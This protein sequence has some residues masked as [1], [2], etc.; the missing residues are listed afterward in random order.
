MS[1]SF[2]DSLLE[3]LE[4]F[5][6]SSN[7]VSSQQQKIVAFLHQLLIEIKGLRANI[8]ELTNESIWLRS[9]VEGIQKD[10]KEMV[11]NDQIKN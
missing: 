11:E 4:S 10:V 6:N 3:S 1:D 8:N 9:S 2:Q 5:I 7:E